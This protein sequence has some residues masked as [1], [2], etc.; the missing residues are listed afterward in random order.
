MTIRASPA[1]A[2][3]RRGAL[4]RGFELQPRFCEG[5]RPLLQE[6]PLE[7]R[8]QGGLPRQ[9]IGLGQGVAQGRRDVHRPPRIQE[10]EGRGNLLE[11]R[12]GDL[13]FVPGEAR[14]GH[15]SCRFG[16]QAAP[17]IAC[18]DAGSRRAIGAQL[19]GGCGE[20]HPFSQ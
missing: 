17:E 5:T 14:G 4:Q 16:V 3:E 11:E 1:A 19:V 6:H 10:H 13:R 2:G 12:A 15:G 9:G 18:D 8:R 7:E 20:A